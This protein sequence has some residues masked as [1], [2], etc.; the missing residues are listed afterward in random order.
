MKSSS[1]FSTG[2]DVLDT[3]YST[4]LAMIHTGSGDPMAT[5]EHALR[6]DP[7]FVSG[8]CL[9]AALLVMTCRDDAR[10]N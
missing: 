2:T 1:N 6:A 9:R 7:G 3:A 8:H 10:R 5:T 4:A